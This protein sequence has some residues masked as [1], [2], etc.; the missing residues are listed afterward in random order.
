MEHADDH[1]ALPVERPERDHAQCPCRHGDDDATSTVLPGADAGARSRALEQEL[2][3]RDSDRQR[4]PAELDY[5]VPDHRDL[6]KGYLEKYSL[7][8]LAKRFLIDRA[9]IGEYEGRWL[10][11]QEHLLNGPAFGGPLAHTAI[12]VTDIGVALLFEFK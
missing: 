1:G 12:D 4:P 10:R 11:I 5:G 3:R 7:M 6:A 9:L 2:R 8:N